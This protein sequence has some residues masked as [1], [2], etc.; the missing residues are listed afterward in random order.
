MSNKLFLVPMFPSTRESV[1]NYYDGLPDELVIAT[2]T[3]EEIL[4]DNDWTTLEVYANR[5]KR[6]DRKL[7]L[8]VNHE[9]IKWEQYDVTMPGGNQTFNLLE[10][11]DK[12]NMLE[13]TLVDAGL[14]FK[15]LGTYKTLYSGAYSIAL[16]DFTEL[17]A[18]V[19]KSTE[20]EFEEIS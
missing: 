8:F 12:L 6:E 3:F 7:V 14:Y 11:L 10:I 5:C 2:K 20:V 17:T 13:I 16:N 1:K 4:F 15:P 19:Y 9:I 18:A